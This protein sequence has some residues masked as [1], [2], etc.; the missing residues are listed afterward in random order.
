[1]AN[2]LICIKIAKTVAY[3]GKV[4]VADDELTT[5]AKTADSLVEREIAVVIGHEVIDEP[6]DTQDVENELDNMTV[7][8]LKEYAEEA[9]IDLKGLT[10]RADIISAIRESGEV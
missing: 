2:E 1:M 10:R 7:A 6:E 3:R 9:G 5:D 8:E 4:Y